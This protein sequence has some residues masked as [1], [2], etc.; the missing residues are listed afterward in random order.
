MFL[1]TMRQLSRPRRNS[2][3]IAQIDRPDSGRR[4]FHSRQTRTF[5]RQQSSIP[6]IQE[7]SRDYL[8]LDFSRALENR[9]NAR[10][11]QYPGNLVFERKPVA[12]MDLDRVVGRGPGDPRGQKL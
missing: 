9:E 3:A 6:P 4:L 2:R 10:V 7:P 11:A 12:A 8:C 1:I 5:P